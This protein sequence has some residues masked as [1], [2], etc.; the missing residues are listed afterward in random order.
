MSTNIAICNLALSYLG[1]DVISSFDEPSTEGRIC[2]QFFSHSFSTLL[3]R[4]KWH[5][6]QN[7]MSLAQV[8]NEQN[9]RFS[10]A[11]EIPFD[12]L[13]LHHLSGEGVE[14]TD[15]PYTV[16]GRIV[17]A[18]VSPAFGHYTFN[19]QD[20]ALLTPLF[21]EALSWH[22]ASKIAIPLTRDQKIF[23]TALEMA[24]RSILKAAINDAHQTLTFYA[25]PLGIERVRA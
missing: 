2:R 12:C 13:K 23:A 19:L 21:E 1:K 3:Q 7:R 14:Y 15:I 8:T 20:C 5:F 11:Y 6:A 4:E 24:E 10:Y 25:E 16:E 17:Y 22:L 18:D 9:N